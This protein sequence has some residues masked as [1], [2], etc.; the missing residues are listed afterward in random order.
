MNLSDVLDLEDRLSLC[1]SRLRS[2][3][4]RRLARQHAGEVWLPFQA[5]F[6]SRLRA[7]AKLEFQSTLK[8]RQRCDCRRP[9]DAGS[10]DLSK[11]PNAHRAFS[12]TRAARRILAAQLFRD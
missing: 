4:L 6:C 10:C 2:R 1:E 9:L 3:P 12:A 8:P 11:S 7:S 5:I